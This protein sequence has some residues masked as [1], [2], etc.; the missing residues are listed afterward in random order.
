MEF[1]YIKK[2]IVKKLI[3]EVCNLDSAGIEIIGN[4][5][6]SIIESNRMI[7]HGLNKDYRP[8]GYTV[9]S[10]SNDSKIVG[11]YSVDQKY[12]VDTSKKSDQIPKFEKIE[13]DI[14][15][16]ISH[17]SD[18][19]K[20]YLITSQEEPPS[21][22][23]EFNKTQIS[24]LHNE[25][26]VIID[27]REL[28]NYIYK[29]STSNPDHAAFY[30]QF[31][32]NF[33]YD[34]DNYEYYGKVPSQCYDY[35]SDKGVLD[36]I[37]E[38]FLKHNICVLYG[39]SG[40]GKTQS[41]IDYVHFVGKEFENYLWISGDDW[42]PNTS[43][44]SIQRTRGGAPVNVAGVF[45]SS[46]TVLIIDNLGQI[47]DSSKMDELSR[48]F[49][50]G[51]IILITSQISDLN[52]PFYLS[53]PSISEDTAI[54]ILG[55]DPLSI[56]EEVRGFIKA[57]R[58]LPLILSITRNIVD[59]EKV[60]KLELYN[61]ILSNPTDITGS[62]GVS[63]LRKI[64]QKLD[65]GMLNALKKISNSGNNVYD[66]SFLRHYIGTL[67]CTNLQRLS[68]VKSTSIPGIV[69]IHDLISVAARDEIKYLEISNSI[70]GLIEASKGN[71]EL[72]VIRQIHLCYDQLTD[73]NSKRGKRGPDWLTYALL[74]VE[75][76]MK[77][78][79]FKDLH[80]LEI[81]KELSLS[82]VMCI[83]DSKEIYSYTIESIEDR[84]EYY[85]LCADEYKNATEL[86]STLDIRI[87]LLHHQGKALR[88]CGAGELALN[89]FNEILKIQPDTYAAHGQISHLGI[90]RNISKEIKEAGQKSMSILV[91]CLLNGKELPLRVSLAAISKLRSYPSLN[92]I[93]SQSPEDVKRLGEIIAMSALERFGQFYEAFVA[94]TSMFSYHHGELCIKLSE[95]LSD[96]LITTPDLVD[97]DQWI[98]ACETLSNLSV[99]AQREN[100]SELAI[101]LVSA[102]LMFADKF[103][104]ETTLKAFDAR[105]ISKAYLVAGFPEKA[106]INA[107]KV[108]EDKADHWLLY[109]KCE[110]ELACNLTDN[111]IKTA[112]K[113]I[114]LILKDQKA[115]SRISS[116]HDL[117]SQ[118]HETKN[119][120]E[121]AICELKFSIDNCDDPKYKITLEARLETLSND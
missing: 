95:T 37:H 20:I 38:H 105:A 103:V 117:K 88:R 99:A 53:I 104:N 29:Q 24:K 75:G 89:C 27:A 15:H 84:N 107:N 97:N 36:T 91:D 94:F 58:F 86:I 31:F 17:Y 14:N 93:I 33:S 34:L 82:S 80:T 56:T 10:F 16:A 51:G 69:K 67:P 120:I 115:I 116:Y 60:D 3:E 110:A 108:P 118:C 63:V 113:A 5:L 83:I 8:S 54:R 71:M 62:D 121:D 43:L 13:N 32:P 64:L 73:V 7:H 42:K 30:R 114:Q 12:F 76:P 96:M 26:I 106:L 65:I 41:S 79:I 92:K 109:R 90:Q 2:L 87:E 45:N 21:F 55:E 11:E 102:S 119:E 68:I 78:E 112:E 9:D 48:G 39:L 72:S 18:L 50:L 40:S 85:K 52:N 59:Q 57:S 4:N 101:K 46:K 74:Q 47:L 100:K 44:C 35:C 98:S 66:L 81:S 19:E 61:E 111:A 70:L 25:K 23:S 77:K 28:A 22:R 1:E 49:S 6:I